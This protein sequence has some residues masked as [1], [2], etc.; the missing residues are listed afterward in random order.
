MDTRLTGRQRAY[1]TRLQ[2]VNFLEGQ[3]E[4]INKKHIAK[5]EKERLI[6][7][8][9]QRIATLREEMEKLVSRITI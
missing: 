3:I 7:P 2:T 4:R 1:T 5:A 8:I 6:A 9:R